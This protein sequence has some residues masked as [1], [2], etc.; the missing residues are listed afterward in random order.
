LIALA[1]LAPV[2]H[3]ADEEDKIFN[4]FLHQDELL[5]FVGLVFFV[6][7]QNFDEREEIC[8]CHDGSL[9]PVEIK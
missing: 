7:S 5:V 2:G 8:H 9:F 4:L 1:F 6:G 3:L